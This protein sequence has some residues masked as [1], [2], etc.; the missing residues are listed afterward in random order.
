[1]IR[2]PARLALIAATGLIV[3]TGCSSESPTPAPTMNEPVTTAAPAVLRQAAEATTQTGSAKVT[4]TTTV[5]GGQFGTTI[6]ASGVVDFAGRQVDL[7]MTMDLL[8]QT[9]EMAIIAD[10][11]KTYVKMSMLGDKWIEA[12]MEQLAGVSYTDPTASLQQLKDVADLQEAGTENVNGA[13]ATKYT[14]TIDID[15][16]LAQA[17][18]S[19]DQLAEVRKQLDTVDVQAA[20]VSVWIDGEGRV[21]KADQHMTFDLGTAAPS[22]MSGAMTMTSSTTFSDFG[23]ATDI[24]AP[25]A[26][27]VMSIDD[28]GG[29][30]GIPT[31]SS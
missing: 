7:K 23:V 9:Q 6:D 28:L 26:D 2:T 27:Q 20:D 14:G 25:P 11:S 19:D 17:G 29:M 10:G 4:S 12:P 30:H 24:K 16:A 5:S 15:E 8:G 18:L 3:V 22:G 21:V 31:P 1:M 13:P